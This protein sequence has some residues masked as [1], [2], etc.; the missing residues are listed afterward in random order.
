MDKLFTVVE[1]E[2]LLPRARPLVEQVRGAAQRYR[3]LTAQVSV[4]VQTHGEEA[5]DKP[6]NPDRAKYWGL[7]GQTR[8]AEERMQALLDELRFLG[9]EVKDLD[10]GLLDFRTKRGS[11]VVLLCWKLGEGRIG[12]WHDLRSGFAGRRPIAELANRSQGPEA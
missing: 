9:A 10:Q 2:R 6:E 3:D 7:V 1:A 12:Y 8:D 4:L 5:M 11:E